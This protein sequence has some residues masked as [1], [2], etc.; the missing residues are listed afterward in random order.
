M[1]IRFRECQIE[2]YENRLGAS[3]PGALV[4]DGFFQRT[5]EERLRIWLRV[6]SGL[7]SARPENFA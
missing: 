5:V 4:L 2:A 6:L 3:E 7:I 1:P